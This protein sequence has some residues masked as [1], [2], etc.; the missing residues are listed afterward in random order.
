MKVPSLR[1]SRAVL[2]LDAV[3]I[4]EPSG[5]NTA[6]LTLSVCPKSGVPCHGIRA[7]NSRSAVLLLLL[8]LYVRAS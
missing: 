2:S 7:K 4:R 8:S 1:H 3:R 5:L 6:L